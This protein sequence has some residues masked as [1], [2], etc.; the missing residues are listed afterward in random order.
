MLEFLNISV[1]RPS[2]FWLSLI[3]VWFA[4]HNTIGL[5]NLPFVLHLSTDLIRGFLGNARR[6]TKMRTSAG[7]NYIATGIRHSRQ[8]STTSQFDSA[9]GTS[10]SQM[11]KPVLYIFNIS[12]YCEKARWALDYFGIAHQV[13]HVMVGEHRRIAK[14]LGAAR[15]SVPFLQ[16]GNDVISG[17]SAI[18][19]WSEAHRATNAPSLSGNDPE[20]VREIEKRLDDITG[21]HVRRFY[22]SDALVSDPKSVRPIFSNGLPM[23]QRLAVILAWPK[24]V[25]K[26]KK[27]MDLGPAQGVESR[28]I[29]EGELA[30]LDACLADGRPFLTGSEFTRADL[31]AASL[32]APLVG[33]K[34]HPAYGVVVFPETVADTM[35]A[36]AERPILRM[37]REAY[38]TRRGRDV[39]S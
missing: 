10:G 6:Q 22:Y 38:A 11:A 2:L 30:W 20:Q 27:G 9:T 17:S 39:H 14:K 12:H 31:T 7:N 18:L 32:L 24:I 26:M 37:V 8:Q 35:Q 3:C 28:A 15:G 13:Q 1:A 16:F 23:W 33:P 36:W 34:E 19:D 5:S 21:V 25:S 29:L 4:R